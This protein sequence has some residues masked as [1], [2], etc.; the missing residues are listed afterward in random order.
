MFKKKKKQKEGLAV[1]ALDPSSVG[2]DITF[3]S[4]TK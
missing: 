4:P 1:P 3:S 2:L